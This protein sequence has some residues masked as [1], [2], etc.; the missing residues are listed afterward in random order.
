MLQYHRRSAVWKNSRLNSDLHNEASSASVCNCEGHSI[1]FWKSRKIRPTTINSASKLGIL[2]YTNKLGIYYF[3]N[4]FVK[5][6]KKFSRY[7]VLSC[8]C[9][10]HQQCITLSRQKYMD[11]KC[12]ISVINAAMAICITTNRSILIRC[13]FL[14]CFVGNVDPREIITPATA[15]QFLEK[16]PNKTSNILPESE[17]TL[18]HCNIVRY[19][20][21]RE[22]CNIHE[23][24]SFPSF[25]FTVTW[26]FYSN[27]H[28]HVY[29]YSSCQLMTWQF[30]LFDM[31]CIKH[32]AN[33]SLLK[34]FA[35]PY[36]TST[37]K[38]KVY[39]WMAKILFKLHRSNNK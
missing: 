20:S 10:K 7:S 19:C 37:I 15:T 24:I 29:K 4:K 28:L 39:L 9:H 35:I 21:H 18:L 1:S 26:D 33:Q 23:N 38:S 5:I 6:F 27:N 12:N 13:L 17:S 3:H 11:Y 25:T 34:A 32:V 8:L 36:D 14:L 22:H 2:R 16:K 31:Y 30:K